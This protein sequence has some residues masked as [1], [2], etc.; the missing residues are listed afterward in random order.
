MSFRSS[1]VRRFALVALLC[2]AS[3]AGCDEARITGPVAE[4]EDANFQE[5]KRLANEGKNREALEAFTKVILSRSDAPEAHLEAGNLCLGAPVK[6]PL[7]AIF[8]FR[9]YIMSRPDSIQ[10]RTGVVQQRIHT[11]EKEFLKTLPFR[12]I[13]GNNSDLL[14]QI[15]RLRAENDTLKLQLGA[16]RIAA[17]RPAPV[18]VSDASPEPDPAPAAPAPAAPVARVPAPATPPATNAAR[19]THTVVKG[20][21]LSGISRRYYGKTGRTKDIF[22]ANRGV[23]RNESDLKI[24]VQLVIPE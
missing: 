10:V 7:Q 24:G 5:G 16:A 14:E 23:M 13:E 3:L 4:T 21:T 6:D 19:R 11:A 12:P 2:S 1:P 22:N 8:H 15:A 9:R 17:A 20:D 18:A